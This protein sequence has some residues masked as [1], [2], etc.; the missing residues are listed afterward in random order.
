MKSRFVA[1]GVLF[2]LS[3]AGNGFA[4]I[5]RSEEVKAL[6]TGLDSGSSSQRVKA[7]KLITRSGI[8]DQD[9]YEKVAALLKAGYA[10]GIESDHV[11]EMSWLCKALAAS[12]DPQY[13]TLLREIAEQA[14]SVKLQH[15][16]EQSLDLIDEYAERSRI[17]NSTETRDADLSDEENRLV[18]MLNSD[19]IGLKKEAA[20]MIVRSIG[21]HEKVY[22]A[23]AERL[24][25][26]AA[27]AR[28]NMSYIDTMAW[29]CQALASSGNDKYVG[30]LEQV[31]DGTEDFKLKSYAAKALNQIR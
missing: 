4:Q 21:T 31:Q 18:N 1:W 6:M 17:L 29:L 20:K 12:G 8:V 16:A 2:C 23:A 28:S 27:G 7:S 15:Y 3:L 19:N 26:M 25:E 30:I 5:D 14:P 13:K 10:E 24:K 11:D 22:E 9:L